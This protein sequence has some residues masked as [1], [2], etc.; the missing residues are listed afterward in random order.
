MKAA[1]RA[2]IPPI[3][4]A[5]KIGQDGLRLTLE[6]PE[7]DM[8]AAPLLIG[9]R[10]K[11]LYCQIATKQHELSDEP[12]PKPKRK[13]G[14]RT[15]SEQLRMTLFERWQRLP[16]AIRSTFENFETYY[17]KTMQRLIHGVGHGQF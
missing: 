6:V 8:A 7:S 2:S 12:P 4:S 11:V 9:M 5:I 14:N 13:N 10:N 15:N 16:T 3:Q 1:F 17:D